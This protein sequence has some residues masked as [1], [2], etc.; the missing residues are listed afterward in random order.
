MTNQVMEGFDTY[1]TGAISSTTPGPIEGSEWTP[2][3]YSGTAGGLSIS[4]ANPA[5]GTR[6]LFFNGF[7]IGLSQSIADDSAY[8]WGMRISCSSFAAGGIQYGAGLIGASSSLYLSL[9]STGQPILRRGGTT[10]WTAPN[11]VPNSTYQYLD[12]VYDR[13]GGTC[14]IYLNGNLLDTVTSITS[15]GTISAARVGNVP[16]TSAASHPNT[17]IDDVYFN[18]G[19]DRWGEIGVII[20]APDA[21]TAQAD[22]TPVGV[23]DGYEALDNV[24]PNSGQY[25]E[26][27]NVGD[28]ST[29]T[30]PETPVGT[31]QVFGVRH[32]FRGQKTTAGSSEVQGRIEVGGNDY[33]GAIRTVIQGSYSSYSDLYETNPDTGLPWVPSDFVGDNVLIGYERTA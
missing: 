8:A 1:P 17:Y 19:G 22:W 31:F 20:L 4:S 24:P 16:L 2:S 32:Y 26:G 13:T 5:N 15:I 28:I 11:A 10:L 14:E 25:I 30:I 7:A 21:D 12:A 33:A 3:P 23:T 9:N 18:T 6:S 29:F 27:V